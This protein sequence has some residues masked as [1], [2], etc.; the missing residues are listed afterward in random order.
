MTTPDISVLIIHVVGHGELA[1][2]GSEKLY[3]LDHAAK[4]LRQPVSGWIEWIEDHPDHHRPVTLFILDVCYAGEAAVTSW[5]AKMDVAERRAWVLAATGPRDQAFGY[6]LSRALVQVLDR[7]VRGELR[8]DPSVRHIPANTLWKEVEASVRDLVAQ[9]GG[10]PQSVLT[11]LVPSHADLSALPFFPNPGFAEA[12]PEER[13]PATIARLGDL[14]ADP[15]HF[16]RRAG[17]AE[18][19]QRNWR[20]G[21]FS[22]RHDHLIQ[23]SN[24]LDDERASPALCV[25]TGKPGAGKS[26]LL[27]ML[28]CAAHPDLREYTK[29]LWRSLAGSVPGTNDRLVVLHARHMTF[30]DMVRAL[31]VQV[32]SLGTQEPKAPVPADTA[33][34]GESAGSLFTLLQES[35]RRSER[36]ITMVI[37]ALDETN[38]PATITES[39]L[40]PL[41]RRH[42]GHVRLLIATRKDARVNA[43]LTDRSGYEYLDLDTTIPEALREDLFIYVKRL[44][45]AAGPYT[46][47]SM[48]QAGNALAE[49]IAGRL[50]NDADEW[51]THTPEYLRLGEF[52]TAGIYV[53]FMLASPDHSS[54]VE[55]AARIGR[56]APRSLPD[57]LEMDFQRHGE[58]PLLRA[59]LTALAFAQGR[60]MPER[61]LADA[62]AFDPKGRYRKVA[63]ETLYHILDNEARL[64]LSRDIDEDGTTLYRLF[65]QGVADWWRDSAS[66]KDRRQLYR[67]LAASVRR[68]QEGRPLWHLAP[69]YLR[70]HLPHHAADAGCLDEVLE[71]GDFLQFADPPSLLKL[72]EHAEGRLRPQAEANAAAYT[73]AVTERTSVSVNA[74]RQLLAVTAVLRGNRPLY[75]TLERSM[76]WS[77]RWAVPIS[78]PPAALATFTVRNHPYAVTGSEWGDVEVWDAHTGE[79]LAVSADRPTKGARGPFETQALTLVSSE[80]CLQIVTGGYGGIRTWDALTGELVRTLPGHDTSVTTMAT[81]QLADRHHL[82]VGSYGGFIMRDLTS[83]DRTGEFADH[84][85]WVDALAVTRMEGRPYV[86][87]GADNGRIQVWDLNAGLV[88]HDLTGHVGWVNALAVTRLDGRPQAVSAGEGGVLYLWDLVTGHRERELTDHRGDAVTGLAMVNLHER[89]HVVAGHVSGRTAIWDLTTGACSATFQMPGSVTAVAMSSDDV[90]IVTFEDGMAALALNACAEEQSGMAGPDAARGLPWH[91]GARQPRVPRPVVEQRDTEWGG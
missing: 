82:L 73:Q 20:E 19:V 85:A 68:D 18:P 47:G 5:H 69:P 21:Y 87:T 31:S 26:A 49:A 16:M 57:L 12:A 23:L 56:A 15:L 4:R 34:D 13:L 86:V 9:E 88:V 79:A 81:A 36:P 53:N 40:Y 30:D 75:T 71:D 41:A 35:Q 1:D 78:S 17:G 59:V 52:L 28:V 22:G 64:Y 60:G 38:E 50:A 51:D 45:A 67:G 7:Y 76:D 66:P 54:R 89:P 91:A 63:W 61:V 27:G 39:L 8:I 3:V 42:K 37:D 11:S 55:E 25:V 80:G 83:G 10:L 33:S 2:G 84:G 90:V 44:L 62:V 43:L 70:R 14:A 65:H 58:Q 46:T 6:R 29:P 32:R 74:R 72:L 24:W 48:R 77:L